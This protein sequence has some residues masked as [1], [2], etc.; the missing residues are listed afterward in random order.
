M[1]T[2]PT[3]IGKPFSSPNITAPRESRQQG[4]YDS[5]EM[6]EVEQND[7]IP[8][9]HRHMEVRD[10]HIKELQMMYP[11]N[12]NLPT[13]SEYHKLNKVEVRIGEIRNGREGNC[14]NNFTGKGVL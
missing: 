5:N 12:S 4:N 9:Q 13:C 7:A 11:T 14:C 6:H 3:K 1:G 8:R 2:R 10:T